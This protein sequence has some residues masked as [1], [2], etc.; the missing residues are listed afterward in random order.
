MSKIIAKILAALVGL[1]ID[2]KQESDK[3]KELAR[4]QRE[5]L[6]LKARMAGKTKE[7]ELEK[8]KRE[9]DEATK[10]AESTPDKK[11]DYDVLRRD[12][13]SDK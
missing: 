5:N 7:H 8:E 12:F 11:D 13:D 4:A 3:E 9:Y 2:R 1:F 10:K 6:E